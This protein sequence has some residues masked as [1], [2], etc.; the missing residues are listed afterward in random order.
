MKRCPNNNNQI[1][2][3]DSVE[4]RSAK[5]VFEDFA[6]EKIAYGLSDKTLTTYRNHFNFFIKSMGVDDIDIRDISTKTYNDF[7]KYMKTRN[8]SDSTIQSYAN[9]LRSFF[10]W[11]FENGELFYNVHIPMRKAQGKI[12]QTYTDEELCVLLKKPSLSDCSF[13]EYKIWVLENLLSCTGLRISSS[14]N[15]K[16]GDVRFDDCSILINQT[17]NKRPFI[18]YFNEDMKR[19]LQEYLKYRRPDSSADYLFCRDDGK[20]ITRRTVQQE[21]AHYNKSRKVSKTSAHLFRHT[22]ARN[23]ILSGLDVFTLMS[24]LQ[25]SNIST[26][27]KYLRTLGLDVKERVNVYNPQQ[28]FVNSNQKRKMR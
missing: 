23:S 11:A 10:N 21:I 24:M 3:N 18:T 19:I 25:H 2:K 28:R 17:K 14:L 5:Q 15:I 4:F 16:V 27:Y 22:F 8:V 20:Q 9:S 6:S 1:Y 13:T 7:I 12:K 26:T